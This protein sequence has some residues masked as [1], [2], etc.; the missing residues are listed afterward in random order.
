VEA[1]L[2]DDNLYHL[3]NTPYMPSKFDYKQN[4]NL[5]HVRFIEMS[6]KYDTLDVVIL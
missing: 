6:L 2:F 5:S 4:I 1:A 3:D